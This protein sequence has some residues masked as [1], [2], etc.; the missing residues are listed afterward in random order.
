MWPQYNVVQSLAYPNIMGLEYFLPTFYESINP[1]IM[2][3]DERMDLRRFLQ[4]F[5]WTC[6]ILVMFPI[7]APGKVAAADTYKIGVLQ[8]F[9]GVYS[10]YGKEAYA[11]CEVAADQINA[12]GGLLGRKVELVKTDTQVK[13]ATAVREAKNLILRHKVDAIIGTTSSGS[14][15]GVIE[16]TRESKMIHISTIASTEKATRERI[17]PYYFQVTPNSYMESVAI[18]NYLTSVD[19][20]TYVTI[21]SDYEWGH[22][23]VELLKEILEKTKPNAKIVGEFWP[24][25]KEADFSSYITAT[26]NKK[27]DVVIGVVAGSAYQTFI[28]QAKGYDFFNKVNFV[29]NGFEGDVMV[30]GKEFPV[31]MRMYSRGAFYA[32]K[33]PKMEA[34]ST[35]YKKI[36]KKDPTC[37]AVLSYDAV[38]TLA[39]AVKK[40]GSFDRDAVARALESEKFNTLR[41]EL[42]YRDIDHQMNSPHYFATSY[43]DKDRGYCVGKDATV[44][45]GE[46]NWRSEEDIKK[47]RAKKGI[48]FVPWSAK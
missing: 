39:D 23:T 1:N 33:G 19:F 41:G 26:L 44:I 48:N 46:K 38:M 28:R 18:A 34:F 20:K 13:V 14:N 45:P 8:P 27:P 10:I 31:G 4:W 6:V 37:W 43:F 21:A 29:S 15:L 35:A 16:I 11:A 32:I 42:Y 5:L 30:L 2:K 9:S 3:G 17:H 36:M 40:A 22:S 47:I 12:S 25:L 24:P 7:V